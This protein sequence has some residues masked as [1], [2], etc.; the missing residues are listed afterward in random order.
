MLVTQCQLHII[1]PS[2]RS[3]A[4]SIFA[5]RSH[6]KHAFCGGGGEVSVPLCLQTSS[7]MQELQTVLPPSSTVFLLCKFLPQCCWCAAPIDAPHAHAC[8]H[9]AHAHTHAPP[10]REHAQQ[11]RVALD[12]F[13]HSERSGLGCSALLCMHYRS[14]QRTVVGSMRSVQSSAAGSS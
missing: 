1:N 9:T 7:D 11:C 13:D 2:S 8:T 3:C 5:P 6:S 12:T 10:R 4:F 14:S